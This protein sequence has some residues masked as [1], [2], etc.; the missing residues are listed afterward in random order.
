M[1][2]A[3]RLRSLE[4]FQVSPSIHVKKPYTIPASPFPMRKRDV[5]TLYKCQNSIAGKI[6]MISLSLR[7]RSWGRVSRPCPEKNTPRRVDDIHLTQSYLLAMTSSYIDVIRSWRLCCC[8]YELPFTRNDCNSILNEKL[9]IRCVL[10]SFALHFFFATVLRS[11]MLFQTPCTRL[12]APNLIVF[13]YPP[14]GCLVLCKYVHI[15]VR[16][17][18]CFSSVCRRGRLRLW[19]VLLRYVL[20]LY[21]YIWWQGKW[22]SLRLRY[23]CIQGLLPALWAVAGVAHILWNA[24]CTERVTLC[25]AR[26]QWRK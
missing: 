9:V 18:E 6:L 11:S 17:M 21:I 19:N 15:L 2:S 20:C 14:S 13:F 5:T 22:N 12:A 26:T 1:Q 3:V 4:R 23:F 7:R 16:G 10:L 8:C 24:S 25:C